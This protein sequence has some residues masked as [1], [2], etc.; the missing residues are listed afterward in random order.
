MRE[1]EILEDA[2]PSMKSRSERTNREEGPASRPVDVNF[3]W[4][5]Y[6]SRM[7]VAGVAAAPITIRAWKGGMGGEMQAY[8]GNV[9]GRG[10]ADETTGEKAWRC[11]GL[12]LSASRRGT[13]RTARAVVFG[14]GER[15]LV[16]W[17][18]STFAGRG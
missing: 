4:N 16:L 5:C 14:R 15:G 3:P 6:R 12:G 17:L 2:P 11:A 13:G 9:A 10:G 8:R 18:G 1:M 7:A